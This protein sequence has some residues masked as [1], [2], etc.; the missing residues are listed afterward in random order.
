MKRVLL[1]LGLAEEADVVFF[2]GDIRL[3]TEIKL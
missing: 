2:F 3:K 1:L